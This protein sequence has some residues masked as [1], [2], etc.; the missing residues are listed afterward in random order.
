MGGCLL[1]LERTQFGT[2]HIC[3]SSQQPLTPLPGDMTP[4]SGF[5]RLYTLGAHVLTLAHIKAQ[6]IYIYC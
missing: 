6:N 3:G 2:Q 5:H 1:L 4:S